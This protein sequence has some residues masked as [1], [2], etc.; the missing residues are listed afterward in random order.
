M[1]VE[2]AGIV[3]PSDV[4]DIP[5]VTRSPLGHNLIEEVIAAHIKRHRIKFPN[6]RA[7]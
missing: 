7:T 6:F 4:L 2:I 3:N 1:N 5:V